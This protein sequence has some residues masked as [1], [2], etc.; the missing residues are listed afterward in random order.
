M[1]HRIGIGLLGRHRLLWRGR[2]RLGRACAA[3]SVVAPFSGF[4]D[5]PRRSGSLGVSTRTPGPVA[6]ALATTTWAADS[7]ESLVGKSSLGVDRCATPAASLA[8]FGA[9]L[10]GGNGASLACAATPESVAEGVGIAICVGSVGSETLGTGLESRD[11]DAAGGE[12]AIGAALQILNPLKAK[13]ISGLRGS[14]KRERGHSRKNIL[15]PRPVLFLLV[16]ETMNCVAWT[17]GS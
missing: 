14:F 9:G 7:L 4:T 11:C 6:S 12:A 13:R 1:H 15:S 17:S 10:M 2:L 16:G 3:L 8:A 5:A